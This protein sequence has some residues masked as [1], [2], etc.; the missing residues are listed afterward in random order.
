VRPGDTAEG[1]APEYFNGMG[2]DGLRAVEL[3]PATPAGVVSLEGRF[4]RVTPALAAAL[5][6]DQGALTD[7]GALA[8]T[9]PDDRDRLT[10]M[11]GLMRAGSIAK[12]KFRQRWLRAGGEA[13]EGLVSGSVIHED[14]SPTAFA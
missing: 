8:A 3:D 14:G 2:D 9:H 1:Q 13:V 11:L 4:L 6:S 7:L 5:G 12:T 10:A